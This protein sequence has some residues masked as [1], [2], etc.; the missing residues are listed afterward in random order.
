MIYLKRYFIIGF[1]SGGFGGGYGGKSDSKLAIDTL[2]EKHTGNKIFILRFE[3]GGRGFGGGH[4]G[5]VTITFKSFKTKK[6]T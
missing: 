6:N 2:H 5:N 4:G 3:K 1:R